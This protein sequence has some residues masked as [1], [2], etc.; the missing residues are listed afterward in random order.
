MSLFDTLRGWFKCNRG[1]AGRLYVVDGGSLLSSRDGRVNPRD[2]FGLLHRIS[3]FAEM[4]KIDIQVVFESEP[5]NRAPDGQAYHGVS[6]RYEKTAAARKARILRAVKGSRAKVTVITQDPDLD[7][8]VVASGGE[9]LRAATFRK[10]L[11]ALGGGEDGRDRHAGPGRDRHRRRG[12]RRSPPSGGSSPPRGIGEANR[13]DSR[14][15]PSG[16]PVPRDPEARV[17]H[18]LI[19]LVD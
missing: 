8:S 7:R 5:L 12:G 17:V 13:S 16:E 14:P 11:E 1:A 10:L 3:R 2:V 6:V 9:V 15:S 18:D 19:D 4:E